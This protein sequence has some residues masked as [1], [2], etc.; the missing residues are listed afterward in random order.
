VPDVL[1]FEAITGP[2]PNLRSADKPVAMGPI[3]KTVRCDEIIPFQL[4]LHRES[5]AYVEVPRWNAERN[6]R[7]TLKTN[8]TTYGIS[9]RLL[10]TVSV[11][12]GTV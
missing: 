6:D 7:D 3:R 12:N 4:L 2:N 10:T 8:S 5:Y 11:A 1:N 9:T